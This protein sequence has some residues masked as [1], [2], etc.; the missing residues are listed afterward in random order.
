MTSQNNQQII[1]IPIPFTGEVKQFDREPFVLS[2][3]AL[4]FFII[5]IASSIIEFKPKNRLTSARFANKKDKINAVKEFYKCL[6]T[7]KTG[8]PYPSALWCGTPQYAI[9]LPFMSDMQKA[10]WQI[11]LFGTMPTLYLPDIGRGWLVVGGPGSGKTFS[12]INPAYHAALQQ[13]IAM[14]LY[15]KKGDQMKIFTALASYYG[16]KVNVFSPGDIY[17]GVINPLEAMRSQEDATMARELAQLMLAASGGNTEGKDFF[18]QTGSLLAQALIQAAKGSKYPDLAMV[19]A[20]SQLPK[21]YERLEHAAE[22]DLLDPWVAISF[23][24]F[25]SAGGSEKTAASIKTT[26]EI[27]FTS[28][29]QKDLIASFIGKSTIPFYQREKTLTVFKLDERRREALAPLLRMCMHLLV[30]ENLAEKRKCGPYVIGLDELPS[31][32]KFDNLAQYIN[33]LRSHGAIVIAGIQNEPQ[34]KEAYGDNGARALRSGLGNTTFFNPNDDESNEAISKRLGQKEVW[35]KNVSRSSGGSG[36]G[37]TSTS[38][39]VHQ[40]PLLS[41]DQINGFDKGVC[42]VESLGYGSETKVEGVKEKIKR[43]KRPI[44]TKI[45]VPK[46]DIKLWDYCENV[47]WAAS[48]MPGL[49]ARAER[50][51]ESNT[52]SGRINLVQYVKKQDY[53]SEE[54]RKRIAEAEKMLPLPESA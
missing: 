22:N 19:Y 1:E 33:E 42:V 18:D 52:I 35:I 4:V 34:I 46:E 50:T 29:I 48:I 53:I 21:F 28:L 24:N 8:K 54:L 7:T 14:L 13:G 17:G 36:G 6:E 26:A 38:W 47:A 2:T 25:R 45:E 44:L 3:L 41:A 32:G 10:I 37:S 5:Y 30:T 16:Y 9:N 39:N 20:I 43:V 40:V 23:S 15:D 27:I 49:V 51:R 12:S 31:L 11:R